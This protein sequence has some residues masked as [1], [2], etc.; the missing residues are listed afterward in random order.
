MTEISEDGAIFG[1]ALIITES[2]FETDDDVLY[3]QFSPYDI[4][5]VY[6][7]TYSLVIKTHSCEYDDESEFVKFEVDTHE[8]KKYVNIIFDLAIGCEP[9]EKLNLF[10]IIYF[11]KYFSKFVK[12]DVALI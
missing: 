2:F 9:T 6:Q 8:Y 12:H 4:C 7:N 5:I 3:K 1:V 11:S 10:F